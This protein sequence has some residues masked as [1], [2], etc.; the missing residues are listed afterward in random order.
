LL[1]QEVEQIPPKPLVSTGSL[2]AIAHEEEETQ[3]PYI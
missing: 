3:F 1:L 2:A